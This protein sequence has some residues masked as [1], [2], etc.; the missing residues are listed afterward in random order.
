MPLVC[1][2]CV[3]TLNYMRLWQFP[4]IG[5]RLKFFFFLKKTFKKFPLK[6]NSCANSQV[7][8]IL[9]QN[10]DL[11]ARHNAST[12][13]SPALVAT[14]AELQNP[15]RAATKNDGE[16]IGAATTFAT[17][18]SRWNTGEHHFSIPASHLLCDTTTTAFSPSRLQRGDD[19]LSR[20][21]EWAWPERDRPTGFFF[22]CLVL[23]A[24][25]FSLDSRYRSQFRHFSRNGGWIQYYMS[26]IILTMACTLSTDTQQPTPSCRRQL[27]GQRIDVDFIF[28][29]NVYCLDA[30]QKFIYPQMKKIPFDLG[31]NRE[32][33]WQTLTVF[34]NVA[35]IIQNLSPAFGQA[36]AEK[37]VN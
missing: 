20:S 2:S 6:V 8:W 10:K 29:T 9:C 18:V 32:E 21:W 7:F 23:F 16:I 24:F 33:N 17:R 25:C 27:F 14:F 22:F 19:S 12:I 35:D 36:G 15:A 13:D 28:M 5:H 37:S 1:N 4:C 11:R 31:E 30:T 3:H 26:D 34:Q